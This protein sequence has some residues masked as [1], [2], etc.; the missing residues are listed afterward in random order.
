MTGPSTSAAT[1]ATCGRSSARENRRH[2]GRQR[3]YRRELLVGT[4]ETSI[5]TGSGS[6]TSTGRCATDGVRLWHDPEARRLPGTLGRLRG[7]LAPA[8]RARPRLRAPAR[9]AVRR[10]AGTRSASARA[11]ARARSCC[12]A[13]TARE[14]FSRAA[15]LARPRSSL[16]AARAS[17]RSTSRGRRARPPGHLG[18][19]S[20]ADDG[21]RA[22]GRDRVGERH[23]VLGRVPRRARRACA[24]GRGD[25]RRLDRRGDADAGARALAVREA[26]LLRR[27]DGDPRAAGRRGL[28]RAGARRRA[29]RGPLPRRRRPGRARLAAAPRQRATASSA[30]PI[31]NVA[32]RRIRD[33]AAF[34]CEYS[35]VHGADA[36]RAGRAA[37]P[38]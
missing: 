29:D 37:C 17:S 2:P 6:R 33:W 12:A 8:P 28:R 30:G 10:A 21:P 38:G 4:R 1:R 18:Q 3:A 27:A 13:R 26:A 9:R 31:R 7:V 19:R 24:R 35:A 36:A 14:V 16:V 23:A 11:V 32:T 22:L 25:R 15:A 34:F 20:G 5:A